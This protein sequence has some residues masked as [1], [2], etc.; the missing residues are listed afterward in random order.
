MNQSYYFESELFWLCK[1]SKAV[2]ADARAS[3]C[4]HRNK[5]YRRTLNP[6]PWKARDGDSSTGLPGGEKDG[7]RGGGFIGEAQR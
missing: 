5:T 6:V 7:G 4:T 2:V 3:V 1:W